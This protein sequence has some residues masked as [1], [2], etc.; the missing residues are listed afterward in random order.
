M[1]LLDPSTYPDTIPPHELAE[2]QALVFRGWKTFRWVTFQFVRLSDNPVEARA[3]LGEVAAEIAWAAGK[4]PTRLVI[5]GGTAHARLQ[6]GLTPS[7]LRRLGVNPV[8]VERF[9]QEAKVGMEGRARVLGDKVSQEDHVDENG[10]FLPTEWTLDLRRADA[11]LMVFAESAEE[12]EALSQAQR[13]RAKHHGGAVFAEERS[14]EWKEREPFGYSDGL[15]QPLIKGQPNPSTVPPTE[16]NRINAG[17]FVLGYQNEYGQFPQSPAYEPDEGLGRRVDLGRNGTYLVF[18]KLEQDVS[19]FWQTF[20]A[21][22]E[23]YKGQPVGP[24]GAR[25]PDDAKA[26]AHWLASRAM[27]RWTNGNST[28]ACPHDAG[29]RQRDHEI[30]AFSYRDDP[31]G[32]LCPAGS[33]VRRANPRDQRGGSVGESWRVVKRHRIIR[34]GRAYGESLTP[35]EAMAGEKRETAHGL[36]FVCLQASIARGFEF[37]QQ[38]WNN[39]PGFHGSFQEPDPI[40]GPGGS[41]FTIPAEPLRIRLERPEPIPESELKRGED[42]RGLPRF[43]IPRGGGYFFVPSRTA[44]ETLVNL[45]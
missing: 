7:G 9:P 43:V 11:M 19:T 4:T 23:R 26:A 25:I 22:G 21:L 38:I 34:R 45:P 33:H 32:H 18:R 29:D 30:N 3:W 40:V 1:N 14:A 36:L 27:G 17:E 42:P 5:A 20:L 41:R 12:L 10:R 31:G 16:Q 28:H 13:A 24:D 15:S 39:N 35:D 6:L 2:I 44:V 37:V 8:V